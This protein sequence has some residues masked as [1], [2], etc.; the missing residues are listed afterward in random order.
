VTIVRNGSKITL[1]FKIA[2]YGLSVVVLILIY[3]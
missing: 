2:T 1:H 3:Y